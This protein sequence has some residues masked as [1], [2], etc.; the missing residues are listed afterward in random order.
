MTRDGRA[1]S[2]NAVSIRTVLRLIDDGPIGLVVMV[3]SGKR[4]QRIGDLLAGMVVA[5]AVPACGS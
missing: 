5:P 3:A 4:R 2:V 1:P